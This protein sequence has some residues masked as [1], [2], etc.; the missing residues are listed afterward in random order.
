MSKL[1]VQD[2]VFTYK[3]QP[4]W[5]GE[6][7]SLEGYEKR[8]GQYVT[9]YPKTEAQKKIDAWQVLAGMSLY[10]P[11]KKYRLEDID[12]TPIGEFSSYEECEKAFLELHPEFDKE[13]I[14][15]YIYEQH[16]I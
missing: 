16:T 3:I 6:E 2:H 12:L 7:F 5:D 9:I 14:K 13:S 15:H 4:P 10:K 11:P 8:M 1:F